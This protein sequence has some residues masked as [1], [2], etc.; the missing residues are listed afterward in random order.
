MIN[1]NYSTK[2]NKIICLSS[3]GHANYSN[4]G[5]DIVCSAVSAILVGGVNALIKTE[6]YGINI[7]S[8]FFEIKSISNET[9]IHDDVV[10]ETI[11]IQLLS[12]E[13]KYGKYIK[14]EKKI[15]KEM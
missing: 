7:E 13:K 14:I 5:K 15:K 10:L 11:L 8:G 9:L 4:Y 6:N 2:N 12:V 3:K 1:V